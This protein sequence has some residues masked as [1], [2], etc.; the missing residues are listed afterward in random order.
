[1]L[2]AFLDSLVKLMKMQFVIRPRCLL[3]FYIN[4]G[5]ETF[6]L[7]SQDRKNHIF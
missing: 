7:I 3:K 5:V 1:V 2:Q 4:H 6:I